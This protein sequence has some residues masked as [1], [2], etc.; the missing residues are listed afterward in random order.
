MNNRQTDWV[1]ECVNGQ[2]VP[3]ANDKSADSTLRLCQI[4]KAGKVAFRVV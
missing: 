3:V 4:I 2:A 1:D